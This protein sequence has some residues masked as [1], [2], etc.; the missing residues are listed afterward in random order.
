MSLARL[1]EGM[2][3]IGIMEYEADQKIWKKY[4]IQ[5]GWRVTVTVHLN[6]RKNDFKWPLRVYIIYSCLTMIN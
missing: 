6:C 2:P 1:A 5:L 4:W 3:L